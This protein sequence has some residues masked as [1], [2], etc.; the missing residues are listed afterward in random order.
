M[1]HRHYEITENSLL[2]NSVTRELS[3]EYTCKAYQIS[4]TISNVQEQTTK[5]NVERK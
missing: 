5:L 1:P 2:I 3:G 4:K